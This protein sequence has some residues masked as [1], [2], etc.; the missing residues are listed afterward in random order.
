MCF[1]HTIENW[2]T[3]LALKYKMLLAVY[4]F[5]SLFQAQF[6][7]FIAREFLLVI[8]DELQ[9]KSVTRKIYLMQKHNRRASHAFTDL[10]AH[11]VGDN[12][13]KSMRRTFEK[14]SY[15]EKISVALFSQ[16]MIALLSLLSLVNVM[17]F[18]VSD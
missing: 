11:Q 9:N 10:Y 15:K 7:F 4:F 16:G 8:Y 5:V 6:L 17:R 18:V 1:P 3:F 13:Y 12:V 2:V 14:L